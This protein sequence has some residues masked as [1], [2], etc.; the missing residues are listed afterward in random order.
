MAMGTRASRFCPPDLERGLLPRAN[1][2]PVNESNNSHQPHHPT[3]RVAVSANFT[4]EPIRPVLA[5]WGRVLNREL[6]LRFAPYD[7][8]LQTVLDP[9]GEFAQND[10]GVNLVL[11]RYED[12]GHFESYDTET[13]QRLEEIVQELTAALRSAP[14]HLPAPI[15]FC[16]CPPSPEFA[17]DPACAASLDRARRVIEHTLGETPGIQCIDYAEID[18]TYPVE[19]RHDAE[20]Q[21][22]G[23]I[24][25]T[26]Q[27]FAALGTALVRRAQ[28]MFMPPYKV[29]AVDCDNTLWRG[30]CGEDGPAGVTLDSPRRM[31][32]EFLLDQREAGM[33]LVMASKNNDQDVFDTFA[34]HPEFPLQ[35]RHF[36]AWRLNWESKAGNLA[37]LAE[38]LNVGLDTFIFLDDNPKEC[39][40]V[41]D[42]APEALP[43]VLPED[44]EELPEF[45]HHIWAFDHP[46]I[47]EEDRQRSTL[48]AQTLEFGR[49][50]KR[51]TSLEEFIAG[52]NLRVDFQALAPERLGRVAQLTQR[53]NQFNCT[54]VRRN[55]QEIQALLADG[56]YRCFTGEVSDRFGEYGLVGVL[57]VERLETEMRVDTFLLSCR[58]LGRGVEH[59]MISALAEEALDNGIY[60][61]SVAF[62]PTSKNMPARQFLDSIGFGTV[63]TM[64]DEILYRFPATELQALRW[65][66]NRLDAG[67]AEPKAKSKPK[68]PAVRR[69]VEFARIAHDLRTP[70]QVV[71]EVR[72]QA[73]AVLAHST[74]PDAPASEVERRLAAIWTELL[75]R[76]ATSVHSNFFDLGGHSLLAVLLLMRVKEEFAVELSV[77]DVYSGTLTLGELA[78]TIEAHQLGAMDADEYHALLAE[79]EGLSDEEVQALLRQEEQAGENGQ[80]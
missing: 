17:A 11:C 30:I 48:Y 23:R 35:L 8:I 64:G 78:R 6:D 76:P 4:A 21:R 24:P 66:P 5:F 42:G 18:R 62:R 32:H 9:S 65:K 49:E 33:L 74:A 56:R 79:I 61:V 36:T 70:A 54:T 19:N 34:A 31:L 69:F 51:A 29:I 40:E 60:T 75:E 63:E 1:N 14:S 28:A 39:A 67:A 20:G 7:Q 58:A 55:E 12:L 27:Y 43:L 53:T 41:A 10:H 15:L 52:L 38:E 2:K 77:D 3:F 45:L 68:A 71:T 25:Y 59:R 57:I 47:T 46:V 16:L 13:L 26:E 73:Q 72:R 22:L 44:I 80:Y 50:I 37:S